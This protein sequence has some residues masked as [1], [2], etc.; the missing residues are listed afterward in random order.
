MK[1]GNKTRNFVYIIFILSFSNDGNDNKWKRKQSEAQTSYSG[2]VHVKHG[3]KRGFEEVSEM[4][5]MI[6]IRTEKCFRKR[7]ATDKLWDSR[8]RKKKNSCC[9]KH[10]CMLVEEFYTSPPLKKK[11]KAGV[12]DD[13][14]LL[15][16][17]ISIVPTPIC[18]HSFRLDFY[19]H[20]TLVLKRSEKWVLSSASQLAVGDHVT[21]ASRNELNGARCGHGTAKWGGNSFHNQPY[22][23]PCSF[24]LCNVGPQYSVE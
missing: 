24:L 12:E 9:G 15:S 1:G 19:L 22:C 6:I 2:E 8:K 5:V 7:T 4:V 21:A 16:H 11:K 20:F 18:S 10:T 13:I 3:W 14:Y 23:S 17:L